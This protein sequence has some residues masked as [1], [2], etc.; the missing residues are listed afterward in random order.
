MPFSTFA[1]GNTSACSG[2]RIL[3]TDRNPSPV[4]EAHPFQHETPRRFHTPGVAAPVQQPGRAEVFEDV[5]A[6]PC[7]DVPVALLLDL[8][9][10]T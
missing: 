2:S 5:Q 8:H 9:K 10:R 1:A 4:G 3:D 6:L 7:S